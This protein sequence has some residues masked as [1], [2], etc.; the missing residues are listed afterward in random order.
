MV[1]ALLG[2]AAI[3]LIVIVLIRLNNRKTI[4]LVDH[5]KMASERNSK[6]S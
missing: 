6:L 3:V 2:L 5:I 4:D 1:P